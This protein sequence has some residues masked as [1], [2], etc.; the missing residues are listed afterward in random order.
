MTGTVEQ[1]LMTCF[2]EEEIEQIKSGTTAEVR[3]V[4]IR[5][6]EDVPKQ[7][8]K[9]MQKTYERY[10]ESIEGL[11]FGDYVDIM[12]ETRFGD[13]DWQQVH[14][15]NGEVELTLNIPEQLLADGRTYFV[16]RNHN[17]KCTI[18]E[19]LDEDHDTITIATDQFS[20]YAILYTDSVVENINLAELN[21][22]QSV[23][24]WMLFGVFVLLM[25]AF[26]VL[27]ERKRRSRRDFR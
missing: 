1:I 11:Q 25:L 12:I 6:R 22:T 19:D 18:L 24:P 13:N 3:V 23:I 21:Q 16:M 2:S 27:V 15:L 8:E 10:T 7:D 4:I 9:V 20:T 26:G 17:D 14:E 5:I